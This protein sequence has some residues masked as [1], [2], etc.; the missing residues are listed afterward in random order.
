LYFII[1][2]SLLAGAPS[3]TRG[4][5][6]S[7][8]YKRVRRA[9]N[10]VPSDRGWLVDYWTVLLGCRPGALPVVG[11]NGASYWLTETCDQ[12]PMLELTPEGPDV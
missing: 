5:V 1:S 2:K 7:T 12:G 10:L 8:P 11:F 6:G 9:G 4:S 3:S